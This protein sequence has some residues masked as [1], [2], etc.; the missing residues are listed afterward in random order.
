[1]ITK[2]GIDLGSIDMQDV[3]AN[4]LLAAERPH[5]PTSTG[6]QRQESDDEPADAN[7]QNHKRRRLAAGKQISCTI[8]CDPIT[9]AYRLVKSLVL[10]GFCFLSCNL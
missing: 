9:L 4:R 8:H 6:D 10:V 7:L 3:Y 1:M 5:R 2:L